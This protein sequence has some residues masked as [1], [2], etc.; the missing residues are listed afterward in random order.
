MHVCCASQA[1]FIK[2]AS[3]RDL[4]QLGLSPAVRPSLGVDLD[5]MPVEQRLRCV[6]VCLLS[7]AV[8]NSAVPSS[9]CWSASTSDTVMDPNM[10]HLHCN[11]I[12]YAAD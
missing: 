3:L 11:K 2:A 5:L 8:G 9:T 12:Q 4:T 10:L 1:D 6:Q 7:P